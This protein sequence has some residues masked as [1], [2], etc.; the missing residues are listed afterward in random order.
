MTHGW[1]SWL[2]CDSLWHFL[3]QLWT[4]KWQIWNILSFFLRRWCGNSKIN[5]RY[6]LIRVCSNEQQMVPEQGPRILLLLLFS[7]LF[8]L[9]LREKMWIFENYLSF[10]QSFSMIWGEWKST[11]FL[12]TI[13]AIHFSCRFLEFSK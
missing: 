8:L 6:I 7:L 3:I 9:N 12:E 4:R 10:Y 5:E 1:I 11:G 2:N 13:S